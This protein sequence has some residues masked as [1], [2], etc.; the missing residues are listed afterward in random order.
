[1]KKISLLLAASAALLFASCES[2]DSS[3]TTET[4]E[5][6]ETVVVEEPVTP[7]YVGTYEGTLPAADASGFVTKV[8]INADG[9]YYFLSEAEGGKEE[10]KVEENGTY[11]VNEN[12][13]IILV[14]P[15]TGDQRYFK[16]I[17]NS[18]IALVADETGALNEG[19]LADKYVLVKVAE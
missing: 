18:T 7:A 14:T 8:T 6:T 3:N 9:T 11:T 15:S 19:E 17:D 13:V 10:S 16:I 2:K 1:M 12:Q 4:T 5:T